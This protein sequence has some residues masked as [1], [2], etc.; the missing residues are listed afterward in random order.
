MT[1]YH[2]RLPW[3]WHKRD[4]IRDYFVHAPNQWKTKLHWLGTY[5]KWSLLHKHKEGLESFNPEP[6][7]NTPF[8]W[9]THWDLG[10]KIILVS[11]APLLCWMWF[12]QGRSQ[13]EIRNCSGHQ[14][15]LIH[16]SWSQL[17]LWGS[18][19][20]RPTHSRLPRPGQSSYHFINTI[21]NV[22]H[23]SNDLHTDEDNT[24]NIHLYLIAKPEE[25]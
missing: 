15:A 19:A 3:Q 23:D 1:G 25:C 11:L 6:H 9:L 10:R 22:F 2:V 8:P 14:H 16:C 21:L 12:N 4:L 20:Q 13:K 7:T 5:T 24:I 17:G 18:A